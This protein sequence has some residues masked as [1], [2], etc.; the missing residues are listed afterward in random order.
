M[1]TV[2]IIQNSYGNVDNNLKSDFDAAFIRNINYDTSGNYDKVAASNIVAYPGYTV[3][4]LMT[5]ETMF[6][7]MEKEYTK[8]TEV[9][10]IGNDL[11]NVNKYIDNNYNYENNRVRNVLNH[12]EN[13]VHL[14]RE[15]FMLVRYNIAFT[16]F[17]TNVIIFSF[18]TAIVCAFVICFTFYEK[19][20]ISW[21]AASAILV[22]IASIYLL[23][24]VI[25]YRQTLV[26]R[27]NDWTKFY[28]NTPDS[29]SGAVCNK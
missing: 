21:T 17:L 4:D 13:D 2:N 25:F 26:R 19:Y 6:G 23:G 20:K 7:K 12:S 24:V 22:L 27:K 3:D 11:R 5:M 29:M 18:F 16:N 14:S 28:F 1:T 8:A 10:K 15:S 9:I